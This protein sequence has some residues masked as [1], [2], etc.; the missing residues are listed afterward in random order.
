MNLYLPEEIQNFGQ[1]GM[2]KVLQRDRVSR[3]GDSQ[4]ETGEIVVY[5]PD[6][7]TRLEVRVEAETVWLTQAQM[8]ELFG[9]DRTVITKHIRK[10]FE[11]RELEEKSNV[12]FLHFANSDK[13]VKMFSLDV[14]ISVGYRVKSVQGTRFRQ[15]ANLVL[16]DFLLNGRRKTYKSAFEDRVCRCLAK[17]EQ[18]LDIHQQQIDFFVRT[19]LPPVEGVFY[20][21]QIFDAYVFVTD[22][23]KSA[24]RRIVLIDNYVDESTLLMLSKRS[25]GVSA[26]VR[27][28][29]LTKDLQLD[30]QRH[31]SQYAL[32]NVVSV[33]NIHDRFLI[34]DDTVYHIGS[35]LKDLGRKL[36]AFSRL[37]LPP[38][39]LLQ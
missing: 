27:T 3:V 13:P 15:W 1:K 23:I 29:R 22:L 2:E 11:E 12:H 25:A 7:I 19:S 32:I 30:V 6:E 39:M 4:S 18:I 21:G 24:K 36:F 16:K 31:N 9:R 20:D 5:Q 10:I 28:G 14:I 37:S 33:Q 17:H 35:S 34:V 26:E 8:A 38:E